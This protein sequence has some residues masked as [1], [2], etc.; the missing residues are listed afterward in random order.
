[1]SLEERY[2][3]LI[4]PYN[5]IHNFPTMDDFKAWCMQGDLSDLLETRK[6]FEKYELFEHLVFIQ[7][8]IDKRVDS[9]LDGFGIHD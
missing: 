4:E 7:M 1:M 6:A 3:E 9:Y 5:F 8:A 2:E